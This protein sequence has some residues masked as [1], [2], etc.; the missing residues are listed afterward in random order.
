MYGVSPHPAHAPENSNN[1]CSAWDPF[2]ESWGR[3]SRSISG[4]VRKKS[5]DC[6]SAGRWSAAGSM[7]MALCRTSVF[8]FAGQTSTQTPHPVQ[9]SG[10]TWIV[11]AIPATSLDRK[12]FDLKPSGA[13]ASTEGS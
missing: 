10:A 5:H 1:G 8:D 6:L 7:L 12:D 11:I 3:A 13:P 9:S 4:I 2:T